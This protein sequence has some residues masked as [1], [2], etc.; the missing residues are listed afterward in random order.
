MTEAVVKRPR[1]RNG[2][3]V[4]SAALKKRFLEELTIS[5]FVNR[6]AVRAGACVNTIYGAWRRDDPAFV[7]AMDLAQEKGEIRIRNEASEEVERRAF[8]EWN[9]G[10]LY[11]HTKR[12]DP[13]YKDSFS[14]NVGV[15]GPASVK[16]ILDGSEDAVSETE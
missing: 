10:M 13:R 12:Y 4:R 14:V 6:A 5:G 7:E 11:F 2:L 15:V 9:D 8:E 1:G 3:R 16:I